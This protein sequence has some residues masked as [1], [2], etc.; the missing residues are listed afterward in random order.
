MRFTRRDDSNQ[1][2]IDLDLGIPHAKPMLELSEVCTALRMSEN[3]VRN[4]IELGWFVVCAKGVGTSRAHVTIE[5]WS[6]EA[7][8][9]NQLEDQGIDT[10]R[11]KQ[12]EMCRLWRQQLRELEKLGELKTTQTAA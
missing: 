12:S 2:P 10:T 9:L 8:R 1:F 11:I 7:W 4:C 5:R 3:T 6:V